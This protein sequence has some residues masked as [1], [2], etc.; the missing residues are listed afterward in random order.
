MKTTEIKKICVVHNDSD[1][2]RA[3]DWI[4]EIT[5]K[6]IKDEE[7][8]CGGK[9]LEDSEDIENF[10][11]SLLPTAIE[12]INYREDKYSQYNRYRDIDKEEVK[13]LSDLCSNVRFKYNYDES[14]YDLNFTGE[15]LIIDLEK[16]VVNM[17]NYKT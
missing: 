9:V 15:I 3:W 14:D 10:I 12:F 16:N 6:T 2:I 4:G 5:L 11:K 8:I 13:R 7:N 1:F 17:K